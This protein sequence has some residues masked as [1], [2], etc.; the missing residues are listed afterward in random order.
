MRVRVRVMCSR[1]SEM[2]AVVTIAPHSAS[3]ATGSPGVRLA[4]GKGVD[5]LGHAGRE[6]RARE[7]ERVRVRVRRLSLSLLLS[8][9]AWR[10]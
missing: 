3:G 6:A 8:L 4:W 7:R 9:L 5:S 2:E 1:V 10:T